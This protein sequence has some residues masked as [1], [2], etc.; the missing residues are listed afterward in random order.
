MGVNTYAYVKNMHTYINSH[1]YMPTCVYICTYIFKGSISTT[2][3]IKWY[4]T[5]VYIVQI[6]NND[7]QCKMI[8][9][10]T[11]ILQ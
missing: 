6:F 5:L 7:I 11:L 9:T 3:F 8:Y 2:Y 10:N 4:F 1:I